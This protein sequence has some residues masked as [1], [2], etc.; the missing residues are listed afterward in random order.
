M[1]QLRQ[2]WS[3]ARRAGVVPSE[4]TLVE[5]R[6]LFDTFKIH[7]N[8]MLRYRPGTFDGSVTLFNAAE[9]VDELQFGYDPRDPAWVSESKKRKDQL[10][11]WDKLV[12][13]D[14]E[15]R[16]VPGN[17]FSILRD[18]NVQVLAEQLRECVARVKS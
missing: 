5:F 7:A 4:I 17:H 15:V 14:V 8:T 6:Q 13:G 11:G 16:L 1:A 9:E 3:E 12:T 18:P 2:V 10:K